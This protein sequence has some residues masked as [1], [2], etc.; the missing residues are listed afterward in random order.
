MGLK[1]EETTY[2]NLD[3]MLNLT[4]LERRRSDANLIFLNKKVVVV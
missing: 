3:Q 1:R 4:T 2:D